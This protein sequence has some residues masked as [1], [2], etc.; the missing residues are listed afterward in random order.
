MTPSP[1]DDKTPK[2]VA[3][4]VGLLYLTIGLSIAIL[5]LESF[6]LESAFAAEANFLMIVL[7]AAISCGIALWLIIKIDERYNWARI[8]YLILFLLGIP[9]F[10]NSLFTFFPISNILSILSIGRAA[11][12]MIALIMLFTR[13]AHEWFCPPAAVSIEITRD[14]KNSNTHSTTPPEA[15]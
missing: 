13:E 3:R 10:I 2:M 1:S 5:I 9:A 4:A 7:F 14:D 15:T 6:V 8:T 12:E 11:L